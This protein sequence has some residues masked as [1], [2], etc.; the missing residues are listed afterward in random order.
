MIIHTKYT[1][2]RQNDFTAYVY[3]RSL[4]GPAARARKVRPGGV[5]PPAL[6]QRLAAR[7]RRGRALGARAAL[8]A[9]ARKLQGWP[10]SF[11]LA[12]DFDCKSLLLASSWP[13]FWANP[14][15][16]ALEVT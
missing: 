16:F 13:N 1:G 10:K 11:K 5:R 6:A 4:S 15:T 14:V 2:R 12:Q 9:G 3:G 7:H 8:G